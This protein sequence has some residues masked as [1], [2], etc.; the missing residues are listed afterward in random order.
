MHTTSKNAI[1]KFWRPKSKY[2]VDNSTQTILFYNEKRVLKNNEVKKIVKEAF[3]K[4]K[5]AGYKKIR[6]KVAASYTRLSNKKV[7]E[8]TKGDIQNKQFSVK[9]TNK[10]KSCPFASKPFT[11]IIK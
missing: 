10:V 5:S 6:K 2:T 1:N 3:D 4:S 7:L 11:I 8:I 9:F